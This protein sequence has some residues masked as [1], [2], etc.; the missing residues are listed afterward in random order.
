MS[1]GW[2]IRGGRETDTAFEHDLQDVVYS[3][4]DPSTRERR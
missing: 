1:I 3:H 2:K 4:F